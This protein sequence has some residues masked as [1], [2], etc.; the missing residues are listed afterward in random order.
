MQIHHRTAH[1]VVWVSRLNLHKNII[2]FQRAWLVFFIIHMHHIMM[3]VPVPLKSYKRTQ[4][5]SPLSRMGL[6]TNFC[7]FI[8]TLYVYMVCA[9]HKLCIQCV[10]EYIQIHNIEGILCWAGSVYLGPAIHRWVIEK[11]L[12]RE[13]WKTYIAFMSMSQSI[14][15]KLKSLTL[16][17]TLG[18]CRYLKQPYS[19]TWCGAAA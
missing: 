7:M 10:S 13:I 14:K 6:N 12:E 4:E 2:Y 5:R 9:Q 8:C 11:E 1:T 15:C 16:P 3:C 19:L 18:L 17:H